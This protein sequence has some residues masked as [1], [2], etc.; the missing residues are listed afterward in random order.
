MP[1]K[2]Q[3]D[4]EAAFQLQQTELQTR[5]SE[6]EQKLASATINL[7]SS[8]NL[9]NTTPVVQNQTVAAISTVRLPIFWRENPD[10]WFVQVEAAFDINRITSDSTKF[11][12]VVLNLDQKTLPIVSDI[13]NAP[14]EQ[15]KYDAIKTRIIKTFAET[16]ESKLRRLLN[17]PEITNEKPS[18]VLQK[19]RHLGHGNCND[20]ILKSIFMENLPENVRGIISVCDEQDLDKLA[21]QADKVLEVMRSS[22]VQV[23]AIGNK[24][25]EKTTSDMDEIKKA[26]ATLTRNFEK[27]QR[28]VQNKNLRGRSRSRSHFKNDEN[29]DKD[30]A[31]TCYY[32]ARFGAKAQKCRAPC[33]FNGSEN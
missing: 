14:P 33:K 30:N 16:S 17:H 15:G 4:M 23:A 28:E 18:V 2:K 11:R 22:G 12:Y 3:E 21:A 29:K 7:N 5:I 31:D 24:N 19:L 13:V 1:P 8:A 20:P 26:M 25:A 32:H 27:L 10:M 9:S 6:L